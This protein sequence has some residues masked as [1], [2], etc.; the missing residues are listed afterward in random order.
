M[1]PS[2]RLLDGKRVLVVEDRYLIAAEMCDEVGRLGGVVVGPSASVRQARDLL[3]GQQVDLALLDV[4][5]DGEEVYPLAEA[6]DQRG[7][8]FIFLTGYDDWMLPE[9]WRRRPHLRKPMNARA[10][11]TAVRRIIA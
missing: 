2:E 10:L 7:V 5:L 4:N 1:A 8:P 6:L 9:T 11:R 3:A